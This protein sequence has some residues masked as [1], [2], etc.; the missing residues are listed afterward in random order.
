VGTHPEYRR[1]GL[2][3]A[4]LEFVHGWSAARGELLQAITGIR[5]Y[6]RQFGYE[7]GG[8]DLGGGRTGYRPHVPK[9]GEGT[10]EP[11]R[12][13]PAMGPDL[14]FIAR[15][16]ERRA[17]R[18]R[19][20]CERDEAT[21]RYELD[22]RTPGSDAK[23]QLCVVESAEGQP[24][25]YLAH[26]ER[27]WNGEI[28]V[29]EYEL[30]GGV[31]WAAVTPSVIRY[32]GARGEE[33]AARSGTEF[34]AFSFWLGGEH[35]AY[36]AAADRLPADHPPYA[37]YLRVADVPGFLRHVA[38]ALEARLAESLVAGHTG[39]LKVS[40]YRDGLR[41]VFERGRLAEAEAWMPTPEDGGTAAFP[42]LTF[43]QLL[44]GYRSLRELR[45]AFADC[46]VRGDETR[47]LL[48]ALFPKQ[49]SHV[50]PLA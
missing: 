21:W 18:D 10:P 49:A 41:L 14:P 32:L 4:Q 33:Y 6:Y 40:F 42:G 39:E 12:I 2:V 15:V 25:G 44:F 38:P 1:R 3:R 43:L 5:W 13:R 34:S 31:S 17:G 50:W 7:L 36:E 37:W 45:Y 46:W 9:L 47:A 29:R 20:V 28:G 19:V 35:P 16:Y 27:L 23:W 26:P 11:Y 22:G 30:D 8:L 48:E 24:V